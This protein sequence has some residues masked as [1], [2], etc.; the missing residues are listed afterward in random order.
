MIKG[1][2]QGSVMPYLFCIFFNDLEIEGVSLSK[3]AVDSNLLATVSDQGD[4]SDMVLS[5]FLEWSNEH[6]MQCNTTKCKELVI[7][8]KNIY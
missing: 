8:K 4:S 6:G 2:T 1:T 3:Y 5:Q 7:R